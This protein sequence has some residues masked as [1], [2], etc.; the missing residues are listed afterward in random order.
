MFKEPLF[1]LIIAPTC[2]NSDAGNL[3]MSKRNYKLLLLSERVKALDLIRKKISYAEMAKIYGRNKS[4]C[5]TT[6]NE[7]NLN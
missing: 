3:D 2:K 6:K 5:E 4:T 1:Y 7:K